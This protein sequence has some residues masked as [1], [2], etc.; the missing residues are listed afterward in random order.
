M[1]LGSLASSHQTTKDMFAVPVAQIQKYPSI[2]RL[3]E[4]TDFYKLLEVC[5][6]FK[7]C[8]H[9]LITV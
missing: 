5:L 9:Q 4:S 6:L 7:Q 2:A 3:C 8:S 1:R